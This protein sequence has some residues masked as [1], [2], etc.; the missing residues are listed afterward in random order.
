[1][2][3][4]PVLIRFNPLTPL[5]ITT[6]IAAAVYLWGNS[7]AYDTENMVT[8][9]I[10]SIV[11]ALI[12]GSFSWI[13]SIV[14]YRRASAPIWWKPKI[15]A[16]LVI[17]SLI[18][19]LARIMMTA[20]GNTQYVDGTGALARG[21]YAPA[22]RDFETLINRYPDHPHIREVQG[23]LPKIYMEWI[24]QLTQG[25][26]YLGA[27][28]VLKH[29]RNSAQGVAP[30]DMDD[31]YQAILAGLSQ[32][33]GLDGQT[34][35]KVLAKKVCQEAANV[36]SEDDY[37]TRGQWSPTGTEEGVKL[38]ELEIPIAHGGSG[39]AIQC[40]DPCF[41]STLMCGIATPGVFELPPGM[42]ATKPSHFRYVVI[43]TR[44]DEVIETCPYGLPPSQSGSITRYRVKW[45]IDIVSVED[46][47][48]IA[49]KM[50][51]GSSPQPC[52]DSATFSTYTREQGIYGDDPNIAE[53]KDWIASAV[54]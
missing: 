45:K 53:I 47:K 37:L 18:G 23:N 26:N 54:K 5:F 10:A 25:A 35:I 39:K 8:D 30:S 19:V 43:N 52:P 44:E 36:L 2:V 17:L 29:V 34:Y 27:A 32:D 31:S 4:S 6:A 38:S 41:S 11:V 20:P 15:Y 1:M 9:L 13:I 50:F 24:K 49:T 22:I 21:D 16:P 51:S 40:N 33:S 14:L 46:G 28:E 48:T 42:I 7:A 12:L 3:K